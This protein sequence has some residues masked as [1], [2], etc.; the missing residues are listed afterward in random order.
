MATA[1]ALAALLW[2]AKPAAADPPAATQRPRGAQPL[3]LETRG[4]LLFFDRN[5][6]RTH[7]RLR[8]MP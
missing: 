3:G 4:R 5:L 8:L 1:L 7:A 2:S 6:S